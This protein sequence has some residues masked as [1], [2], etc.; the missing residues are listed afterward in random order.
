VATSPHAE[1][2][3][4]ATLFSGPE[5][6]P[7]VK[8]VFVRINNLL[9]PFLVS[10]ERLQS[11]TESES[12]ARRYRKFRARLSGRFEL[13]DECS[14]AAART[15]CCC[16]CSFLFLHGLPVSLVFLD[17]AFRHALQRRVG[18][19]RLHARAQRCSRIPCGSAKCS[20]ISTF[21]NLA[22]QSMMS[23]DSKSAF[24]M[25]FDPVVFKKVTKHILRAAEFLK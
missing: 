5:R 14:H 17:A 4:A 6:A 2:Q 8:L 10:K 3:R 1:R 22:H 18:V 20:W 12:A 16:K 9:R 19:L 15:F 24:A 11:V 25:A 7:H 23:C 21:C 13:G